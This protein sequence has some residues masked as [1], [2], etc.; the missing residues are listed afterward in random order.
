MKAGLHGDGK[1][2]REKA[3]NNGGNENTPKLR[4]GEQS[5]TF[6]FL[7]DATFTTICFFTWLFFL[8]RLP[9]SSSFSSVRH[10]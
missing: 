1:R 4:L 9:S 5:H 2:G 7:R 10:I 6:G 8:L 3:V